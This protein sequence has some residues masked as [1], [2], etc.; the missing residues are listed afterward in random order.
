MQWHSS[1]RLKRLGRAESAADVEKF[2]QIG[3]LVQHSGKTIFLDEDYGKGLMYHGELSGAVW[4]TRNVIRDA[5]RTGRKTLATQEDFAA[6]VQQRSA[7]Y[8]IVTTV[9]DFAEQ[10]EIKDYVTAH[11]PEISRN[12]RFLIFRLTPQ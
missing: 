7:E 12:G 2:Q 6:L 8:F 5:R 11:Y 10:T 3:E 4:P 9:S 1:P